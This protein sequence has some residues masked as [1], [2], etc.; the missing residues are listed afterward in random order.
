[1]KFFVFIAIVVSL[2]YVMRWVQQESA[3]RLRDRDR[4]RP[5]GRSTDRQRPAP[6]ATDLTACPRCGSYVPAE[7]P[8]SCGRRDCPYPGVG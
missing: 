1:M 6:R 2:W 7:F 3:R 4:P 5:Q 8:V